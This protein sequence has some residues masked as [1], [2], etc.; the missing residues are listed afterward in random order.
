MAGMAGPSKVARKNELVLIEDDSDEDFKVTRVKA[1]TI[2]A[3][4][5]SRLPALSLSLHQKSSA[6]GLRFFDETIPN[7]MKSRDFLDF[8]LH[9]TK[10]VLGHKHSVRTNQ[11]VA[12]GGIGTH[13]ESPVMARDKCKKQLVYGLDRAQRA[14]TARL[15][16]EALLRR[17]AVPSAQNVPQ[18]VPVD[19]TTG[20]DTNMAD[21]VDVED[22]LFAPS[23]PLPPRE[24]AENAAQRLNNAWNR[25]LPQLETPWLRYYERTHGRPRDTIPAVIQHECTASCEASSVSKVKCLYPTHI[26]YVTVSTCDCKPVPVLMEHGVFPASPTRTKTGLAIDLLDLY[27]ALFERSCDAITA[28]AAALHTLY[29]RW[30]F[31]KASKDEQASDPYRR[32]LIQAVQWATNLRDRLEKWVAAVLACAESSP[33]L[34]LG[35]TIEAMDPTSATAFIDPATAFINPTTAFI[36]PTT[37]FIDPM[38][39]FVDSTTAAFMLGPELPPDRDLPL[40]E[41]PIPEAPG[42]L[43]A[44][45][46][47]PQLK[48]GCADRVLR[49]WCPACFNLEEWGQPL[50]GDMQFGADGCF[51]YHHLRKAGDCPISYDP[52]YFIPKHKVDAVGQRLEAAKNRPAAKA[53][54]SMPQELND[55]CQESWD[56]ANET[57]RKADPKRYDASGIFVMTCR[58]GQVIFLC[59]V[60]TPGEQQHYIVAMLEE[61]FTLLPLHATVLQAYD[62]GCVTEHSLN[63]NSRRIW[64]IDQY[65]TFVSLE[66]RDGLGNWIHRQQHKNMTPKHLPVQ[67]L[68][69]EWVAQK[70]AQTSIR[71]HA[72]AR[73]RRELGKVLL[74][75]NQIDSIDK[76]INDTKKTLH[77][78]ASPHS[79]AV[80]HS[81]EKTHD[82]LSREA[83]ELYTSLN[84]QKDFPELRDLPLEFAQTLLMMRDLKINIRK[85]A[86]SSFF[87]WESLDRAVLGRREALGTKLHQS[88][89]KAMSRRQPSLLKA[90]KKFNVGCETL[91]QLCPSQCNIPIPSPLSVQLN[92]LRNDPSLH[93]DVWIT[94]STGP[95]PQWLNDED[96]RDG[97]R[98]LHVVDRCAEEVV[99]LNMERENLRRWLLEERKVDAL[100]DLE[101][102]WA[103]CLRFQ[104]IESRFVT[105]S[106]SSAT[107]FGTSTPPFATPTTPFAASAATSNAASLLYAGDISDEDQANLI[108]EVL[109]DSDDEEDNTATSA[110]EASADCL[111]MQWDYMPSDNVDV[112]F[113]PD[114]ATRNASLQVITVRPGLRPLEITPRDLAPFLRRN[115][116]L[117]GFG[118]NGVVASVHTLSSGDFSP[119]KATANQCA[120]FSTYDLPCVRY[121]GSYPD[122]WRLVSPTQYWEK[123][124]WLI[125]IH[126]PQ[127]EHWVLVVVVVP[128]QELFFFDSMASR[129]GWRKDLRDVMVLIMR[130]VALSNR[131][132]HPLHVSTEDPS[133]RW[134]AHP[135]FT[136]G[137]PWQTNSYDCGLWVLCMMAAIMW[138]Y[139]DV[140]LS[141]DDMPWVRERLF[142]FQHWRPS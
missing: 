124:L 119:T 6:T 5:I 94:P 131:N 114:L 26:Q 69:A 138:G 57:K 23:A 116:Q 87:E 121:K 113:I 135:L 29:N 58:H 56:A 4:P 100:A 92:G 71:A 74:L 22:P 133:E 129:R 65:A 104:D 122:L 15:E 42:P 75:Q 85:R 78:S 81:L 33:P 38:T 137:H 136:V 66:G 25:L 67:Q 89:H 126:R 102:S 45:G 2:K 95:I 3:E 106:T 88:T 8:F 50:R 139:R 99:H 51:S 90:I 141:E 28:L 34:A 48:P 49:E 61:V 107:T 101:R 134:A 132:Q 64:M 17:E 77:S 110:L 79:L 55:A 115:G 35:A 140:H 103:P 62:V 91:E 128:T 36:D 96:V 98:S 11:P 7:W 86:I 16:L 13:F 44:S 142:G 24:P 80:L 40:P 43:P 14:S 125:P 70:A 59:N 108:E 39:T 83:E 52:S 105:Q 76:A 37:A 93:E 19:D 111:D 27:R 18:V 31:R 20:S 54:P 60:D 47:S 63:L 10:M 73:L 109:H 82:R 68:R 84:I 46:P 12:R 32:L 120:V 53:K 1:K 117:D 41:V 9:S 30:G 21:W 130:L 123:L 97:I 118:L 72:P 112:S 127:M